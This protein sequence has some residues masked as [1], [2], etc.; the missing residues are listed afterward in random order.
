MGVYKGGT[1]GPSFLTILGILGDITELN[2]IE[3]S[4]TDYTF[5]HFVLFTMCRINTKM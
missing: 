3:V 1:A 2:Y 5:N 4:G